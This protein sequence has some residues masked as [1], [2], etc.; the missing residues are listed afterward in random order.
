MNL[1]QISKNKVSSK[2]SKSMSVL[3][4]SKGNNKGNC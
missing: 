4:K 2:C 3:S 1:K